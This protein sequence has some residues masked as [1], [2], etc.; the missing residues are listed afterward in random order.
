MRTHQN[1]PGPSGSFGRD[2]TSQS[3]PAN[4]YITEVHIYIIFK[5]ANPLSPMGM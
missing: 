2:I 5:V 1:T 3:M 4:R